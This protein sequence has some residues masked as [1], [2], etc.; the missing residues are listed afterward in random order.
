[1]TKIKYRNMYAVVDSC[2]LQRTVCLTHKAQEHRP[3]WKN[4]KPGSLARTRVFSHMFG[5]NGENGWATPRGRGGL[6]TLLKSNI[7]KLCIYGHTAP[8][9]A[10]ICPHGFRR[11]AWYVESCVLSGLMYV[12]KQKEQWMWTSVCAAHY[13]RPAKAIAFGCSGIVCS[14]LNRHV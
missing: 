4:K 9:C 8:V 2:Y 5:I 12:R 7:D 13:S 11:G 1:M 10:G 3:T 6:R 14:K